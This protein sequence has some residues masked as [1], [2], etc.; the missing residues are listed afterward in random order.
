[1]FYFIRIYIL[2]VKASK[3]R[4]SLL[5]SHLLQDGNGALQVRNLLAQIHQNKPKLTV[6]GYVDINRQLIPVASPS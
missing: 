4:Q 5:K 3:L 2:H 1:M 6:Y